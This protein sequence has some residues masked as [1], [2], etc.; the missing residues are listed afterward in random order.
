MVYR[1]RL[2]HQLIHACGLSTLAGIAIWVGLLMHGAAA[3]RGQEA[4]NL[5]E[6]ALG[7]VVLNILTKQETTDGFR[8]TISF[9]QGLFWYAILWIAAGVTAVC[10]S[11]L[12]RRGRE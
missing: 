1:N 10:L 12:L 6:V 11:M 7:P 8:A 4:T 2:Q 5:Y 3:L 9:E